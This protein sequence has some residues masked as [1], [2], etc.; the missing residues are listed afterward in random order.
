MKLITFKR[1]S[2][3]R[4]G[5]FLD[6]DVYDITEH[7]G[8]MNDVI[9]ANDV[10]G[11]E[12]LIHSK[13]LTR[14]NVEQVE[15]LAPIQEVVRNIFC[16]GWNYLDHFNEVK[17]EDKTLPLRPTVFTKATKA[18]TGPYDE[19]KIA[20]ELSEYFDYE[21]E[22][23]VVI[24]KTGKNIDEKEADAHIFGYMCGNDMSA[25]DIQNAHGGQ[26]FMGKSIDGTCPIGPY[27][28]TKE[29][30]E[31]IQ[32]LNIECKVN[33]QTVQSSNTKHMIFPVLKLISYLSKGITLLPGDIILTGTPS[34]VGFKKQP[35][36]LLGEGDVVEVK[37]DQLGS[38]KNKIRVI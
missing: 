36:L 38:I 20:K 8:T 14:V 10:K 23:A 34:G 17:N 24:G 32:N 30:I 12:K 7:A 13:P 25:R 3:I 33:N 28:V 35:P 16:I 26:W 15:I 5:V 2:D 37:I 27:L 6:G 4:T 21:A 18:V 1:H 11:I 9:T 19:I 31:D 22:L 29:E